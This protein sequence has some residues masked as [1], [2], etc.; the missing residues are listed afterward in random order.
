MQSLEFLLQRQSNGFLSQPAPNSAELKII[1]KAATTVPDHAGLNPYR[2]HVIQNEGL[3]KLTKLFVASVKENTDDELKIAKA[4]KMAYRA[5]MIIVVS[6]KY[7]SHPKV[8]QYEQ[9]ITAGCAAYAMQLAA[10]SLDYGVMW[11]TGDLA[12]SH[13]VKQGLD[14]EVNDDII[15]FLYIGTISKELPVKKRKDPELFTVKI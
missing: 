8:P 1:L 9:L 7:Q 11:R 14:I 4:E 10:N 15:G 13:T 5:P 12:L 6:S 3:D 2:F